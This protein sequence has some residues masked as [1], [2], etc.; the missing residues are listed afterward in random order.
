MKRYQVWSLL[1]AIPL[2][3]GACSDSGTGPGDGKAGD[4]YIRAD[5]SGDFTG[6]FNATGGFLGFGGTGL[7]YGAWSGDE[8][9][10][11]LLVQGTEGDLTAE[12]FEGRTIQLFLVN[13]K[14]GKFTISGDDYCNED[15]H[16]DTPSC[17]GILVFST[18]EDAFDYWMTSGTVEIT[19][20]TK[21][22]VAGTFAASGTRYDG[23]GGESAL[24]LKNG[25]FD[26]RIVDLK[27]LIGGYGN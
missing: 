3:I 4:S 13:P 15:A 9:G 2:F 23:E 5:L 26:V 16:A 12:E 27:D 11:I 21:D 24:H 17:I 1:L 14:K 7:V 19:T 20:L 10:E 25:K 6:K 22:R 18:D 8:S